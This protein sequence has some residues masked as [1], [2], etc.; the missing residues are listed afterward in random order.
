MQV[1]GC[2]LI[3]LE[4]S[5]ERVHDQR[6]WVPVAT[7]LQADVV[8]G[9]DPREHRQLRAAQ[10][11]D[12]TTIHLGDPDVRRWHQLAPCAQELTD[13]VALCHSQSLRRRK[14]EA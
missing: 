8:L 9:T 2:V 6:R 11:R 13:R 10:A 4:R 3:E 12:T 7:L 1:R 14:R 5:R